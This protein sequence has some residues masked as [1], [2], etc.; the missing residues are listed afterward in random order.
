MDVTYRDSLEQFV[1]KWGSTSV[2]NLHS[3]RGTLVD[4]DVE[5]LMWRHTDIQ[6]VND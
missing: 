3:F 6:A 4:V 2:E 5:A 1:L